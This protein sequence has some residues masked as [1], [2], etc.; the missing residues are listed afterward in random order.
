MAVSEFTKQLQD[1]SGKAENL[2]SADTGDNYDALVTTINQVL[3]DFP[4]ISFAGVFGSA[5]KN[6][7]TKHSDIDIAVAASVPLSLELRAD[8]L[9]A[10]SRALDREIDL[11]DLQ[12]VTGLILQQA[13]CTGEIIKKTD[14][15]VYA[16]LL[17][18]MLFNQADMMPYYRRILKHRNRAW[19][20][21]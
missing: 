17:Q 4:S 7:L 20:Q 13:L 8:L 18:R 15:T 12:A 5:V 1:V 6:R 3:E 10:L 21:Q 19:L 14:T 9:T 11:I 2:S 16:A